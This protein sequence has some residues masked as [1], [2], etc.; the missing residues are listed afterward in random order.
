MGMRVVYNISSGCSHTI[1]TSASE[2]RGLQ[3][4]LYARAGSLCVAL[5]AFPSAQA[6]LPLRAVGAQESEWVRDSDNR[7]PLQRS[8]VRGLFSYVHN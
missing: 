3:V 8:T 6:A 5:P 1:H 7:I 4:H 2:Q